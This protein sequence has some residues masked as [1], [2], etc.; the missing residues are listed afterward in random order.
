[1]QI[2]A[3]Q[4]AILNRTGQKTINCAEMCLEVV[5][6]KTEPAR[7]LTVMSP[8]EETGGSEGFTVATGNGRVCLC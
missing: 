5:W 1:M 6:E 4:C 7:T 8:E 2:S 3:G